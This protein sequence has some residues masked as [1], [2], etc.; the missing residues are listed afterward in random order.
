MVTQAGVHTYSNKV[1]WVRCPDLSDELREKVSLSLPLSLSLIRFTVLSTF[2]QLSSRCMILKALTAAAYS[3]KQGGK[4][5][6]S[7]AGH[8][9][10]ILECKNIGLF[11]FIFTVSLKRDDCHADLIVSGSGGLV[12]L[13]QLFQ[14]KT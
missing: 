5:P 9:T 14:I 8:T 3:P 1:T 4:W 13:S 12:D 6:S 2:Y 11:L 10:Y 7:H